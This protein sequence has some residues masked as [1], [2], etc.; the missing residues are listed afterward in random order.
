MAY[1]VETGPSRPWDISDNSN[2]PMKKLCDV[3]YKP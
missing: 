1:Y 2:A 3:Y